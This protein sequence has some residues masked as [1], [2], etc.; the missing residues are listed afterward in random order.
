MAHWSLLAAC[1]VL[2]ASVVLVVC[3]RRRSAPGASRSQETTAA[4]A[5]STL[6]SDAFV[7]SDPKPPAA[8]PEVQIR[9]HRAIQENPQAAAETLQRWLRKAA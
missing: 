1:G 8:A 4:E 2:V 6:A 7:S 9:I 5:A 3:G